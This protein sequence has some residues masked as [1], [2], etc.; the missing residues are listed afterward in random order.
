[1]NSI[2][3]IGHFG[4]GKDC[5]DGQTVKTKNLSNGLKRYAETK[6]FEVDTH[7]WKKH[8]FRLI[9]KIKTAFKECDAVIMLPAHNGIKVF[10]PLLA[11]FKKKYEKKIFYDVIGGWLPEFLQDKKK[12]AE[13]L[14]AFD[15][16]WVETETMKSK[17]CAFG[18][19]NITV[20]PNFKQLTPLTED[21]L[22]YPDG[23]PYKLCT[24][25][26]VMMEKGIEDA[27]DA[28]KSVNSEL[29]YIAY[30]LDIY[31]QVDKNYTER[32]EEIKKDFPEYIS[33][34]GCVDSS[35]SVE[36]LKNYFALLFPTRFYTEGIPGTIIDAYSA[37]VPVISA[38]WESFS[39][40][41]DADMTGIGYEFESK[42]ALSETL[43]EIAEKPSRLLNMK[44]AC[45]EKANHYTSKSAIEIIL[46]KVI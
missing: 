44:N 19:E 45:I 10:A 20:I 27:I 31:G 40:V 29:G 22:V 7:G 28:V 14:K 24:F 4:F 25:S 17:L 5:L 42:C 26:R 39:D 6:V 13:A 18:F 38:R 3:I 32:F 1:M 33:Y 12:L 11:Y 43:L 23:T 30:S 9:G 21:E 37:G 41:I 36:I 35:K 15:G 34:R 8:P 16:V 46:N 2:A